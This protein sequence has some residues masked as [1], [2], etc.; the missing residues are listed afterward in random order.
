MGIQK[1]SSTSGRIRMFTPKGHSSQNQSSK[2]LNPKAL[3]DFRT[4]N[5]LE[6]KARLAGEQ[7]H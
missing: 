2:I 5:S 6:V 4:Q 1:T 7:L 3:R